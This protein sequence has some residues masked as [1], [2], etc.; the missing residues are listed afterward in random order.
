MRMYGAKGDFIREWR[1]RHLNVG[2]HNSLSDERDMKLR[3]LHHN[4]CDLYSISAVVYQKACDKCIAAWYW[5]VLCEAH[6]DK[7][8]RGE[9]KKEHQREM[10]ITEARL[11]MEA[12]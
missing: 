10:P 3:E 7:E 2:Y 1:V 5:N 4:V 12:V 8:K 9:L 6:E 11:F